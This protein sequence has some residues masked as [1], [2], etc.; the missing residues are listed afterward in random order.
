VLEILRK[1]EAHAA[2]LRSKLGLDPASA[3]RVGRDLALTRRLNTDA[4]PL[5]EALAKIQERRELTAGD[6]DA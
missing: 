4:T 2:S 1:Y 6:A 5:A 3:A